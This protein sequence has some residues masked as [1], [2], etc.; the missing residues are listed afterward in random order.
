LGLL[1]LAS[2]VVFTLNSKGDRADANDGESAALPYSCYMFRIYALN[3]TQRIVGGGGT[4][5]SFNEKD[6]PH[7]ARAVR[8]GDHRNDTEYSSVYFCGSGILVMASG[9]CCTVSLRGPGGA[10]ISEFVYCG[11]NLVAIGGEEHYTSHPETLVHSGTNI[12]VNDWVEGSWA[13]GK[14]V[15]VEHPSDVTFANATFY[16]M[17]FEPASSMDIPEFGSLVVSIGGTAILVAAMIGR[18]ERSR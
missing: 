2:A 13:P 7:E 4:F 10:L 14:G 8:F 15:L 5:F 9:G 16:M 3:E 12:L 6:F 18:R 17:V 1:I 11:Q